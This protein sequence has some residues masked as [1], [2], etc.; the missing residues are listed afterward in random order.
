MIPIIFPF[1]RKQHL[2][3]SYA[4]LEFGT[5]LDKSENMSFS[6][7]FMQF[8]D[9]DEDACFFHFSKFVVDRCAEDEHGGG[10]IHVGVDK[11]WNVATSLAH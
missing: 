7:I 5:F 1:E 8:V 10:K 9:T 4:F 11:W 6:L 2:G 3:A